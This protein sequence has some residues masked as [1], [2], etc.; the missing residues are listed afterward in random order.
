MTPTGVLRINVET[1]AGRMRDDNRTVSLLPSSDPALP[2]DVVESSTAWWRSL[3]ASRH[4]Q[5][6]KGQP[7]RRYLQSNGHERLGSPRAR[8]LIENFRSY[9]DA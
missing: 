5:G 1:V 4:Y 8:P 3:V 7:G 2:V 6:F 9:P